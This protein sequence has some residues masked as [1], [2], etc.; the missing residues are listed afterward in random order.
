M[1]LSEINFRIMYFISEPLNLLALVIT[2]L[3]I[4]GRVLVRKA[5]ACLV[6]GTTLKKST[7]LIVIA[8][9]AFFV[10]SLITLVL[11]VI[12][13]SIPS[14]V[15]QKEGFFP[16][17]EPGFTRTVSVDK[18]PVEL[19]FSIR[20]ETQSPSDIKLDDVVLK[21]EAIK[22][23]RV[24]GD[25]LIHG[26]EFGPPPHIYV[27]IKSPSKNHSQVQEAYFEYRKP[28]TYRLTVVQP[29]E[30]YEYINTELQIYGYY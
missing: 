15:L 16:L 25:R 27:I 2:I 18:H 13:Y 30:K 9:S 3:L 4:S 24:I 7:W 17:Y 8:S 22:D 6:K 28:A 5:R 29:C 10:L 19:N 1:D 12:A 23:G 14:Y 11:L 26:H 21:L 20:I